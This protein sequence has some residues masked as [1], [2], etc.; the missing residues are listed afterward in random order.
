ML[1]HSV[2]S[3]SLCP[4]GLESTRLFCPWDYPSKRTRVDNHFLPQGIFLTR[5]RT[6]VSSPAGGVRKHW[7]LTESPLSHSV[8]SESPRKPLYSCNSSIPLKVLKKKI[9]FLQMKLF[10]LGLILQASK[11]FIGKVAGDQDAPCQVI[12]QGFSKNLWIR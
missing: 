3:N 8:T 4:Y 7:L 12:K 5:D 1:S 2:V 9:F 10:S 6:L 11:L